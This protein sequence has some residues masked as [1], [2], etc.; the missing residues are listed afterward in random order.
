VAA[1]KPE[2]DGFLERVG[3]AVEE[4]IDDVLAEGFEPPEPEGPWERRSRL[5]DSW[6]AIILAV[7][8]VATTWATFEASQW[9]GQQA[10]RQAV[11]AIARSDANQAASRA[12]G[13]RIT[14]SQVWLS[15]LL[16]TAN[17]QRDRARF[18]RERFSP[19]LAEA[20]R[21]WLRQAPAEVDEAGRAIP[22]GT[23]L[24]LPVYQTPADLEA[25]RLSAVAEQALV[26][27]DVAAT[28]STSFVLLAVVFALS[29]FFGSVATKFSGPKVQALLLLASLVLL[30]FGVVRML[31]LPQLI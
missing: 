17:D 27:A 6:T 7:A 22:P 4:V 25:Q 9:S 31:L 2:Q 3:D 29:L 24:D 26:D 12:A 23:P 8:A 20:Q 28:R 21:E 5:L 11:S 13:E 1:S 15:W 14:D 30:L 10:D 16:A 19:S 18:F